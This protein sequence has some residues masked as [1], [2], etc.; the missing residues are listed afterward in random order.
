M[1]S[2]SRDQ[3]PSTL[4]VREPVDVAV[5]AD[6]DVLKPCPH[7]GEAKHLYQMLRS[8][9]GGKPYGIDCVGCGTEFIPREGMD[10]IAVWNRRA[11]TA[12]PAERPVTGPG[13]TTESGD[14]E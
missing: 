5:M 11:A 4:G 12:S 3:S 2:S 7:C 9:G 10:V 14:P 1:N 8:F 6:G 13:T